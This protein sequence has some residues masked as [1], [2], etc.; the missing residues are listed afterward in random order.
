MLKIHVKHY[1]FIFSMI[2]KNSL[3]IIN[4]S[5]HPLWNVGVYRVH[6]KNNPLGKIRYLWNYCRFFRQIYSIYRGGLKP[7]YAVNFITKTDVI[8]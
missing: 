7:H 1:F 3:L 6:Q 4:N 2:L 8:Q 5:V